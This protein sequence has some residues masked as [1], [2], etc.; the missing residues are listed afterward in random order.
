[1]TEESEKEAFITLDFSGIEKKF[2]DTDE[3]RDFM[4]SQLSTWSWL[5]QEAQQ[6]G[7]LDRVWDLFKEY[8]TQ[9][10]KF[11]KLYE[12]SSVTR[13]VQTNL[14]NAFRS[15]TQTAVIQ[16]FILTETPDARFVLALRDSRPSQ[17]AAYALAS[18]T[19]TIINASNP[20]AHE[21]ALLANKYREQYQ[22]GSVGAH[23]GIFAKK[24]KQLSREIAMLEERMRSLTK[25]VDEQ[26]IKQES[27][28]KSRADKQAD[29]LEIILNEAKGELTDFKT[30]KST[31]ASEFENQKS[32]QTS[33]FERQMAKQ[34]SE[35]KTLY[36]ETKTRLTNLEV[37][38]K[39]K[40]ELK[41]SVSYWT[42]KRKNH[43]VMV[44]IM[45]GLTL[46]ITVFFTM[47]FIT[48]AISLFAT[49]Q[50]TTDKTGSIA[51]VFGKFFVLV[52]NLATS[53]TAAPRI[54]TTTTITDTTVTTTIISNENENVWSTDNLWK[55]TVMILISTIGVWLIRL[56]TKIFT[57]H[58]HLGIDTYER[59]T[60][61]RTYFALLAEDK[62]LSGDERELIL[63]TLF[64]PSSSGFIKDDGPITIPETLVNTLKR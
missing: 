53:G 52:P 34:A 47:F 15:Q 37:T 45:A 9:S 36:D 42:K 41:S 56:T 23:H 14:I 26:K 7:N 49:S 58:L 24:N 25:E 54:T 18:L 39:K 55:I 16:G 44:I 43:Q 38:Y 46:V 17:V 29:D 62:G 63:Q 30:Q 60:M 48:N 4:Q 3:L 31:Q 12:T 33:D 21:G 32:T 22:L 50:T 35:S 64:R 1:M 61:I 5:E 51:P 28:F 20:A 19:N 59:V 13:E 6:D 2:A 8:F 11:I 40:I 10:D 57:S 27:D